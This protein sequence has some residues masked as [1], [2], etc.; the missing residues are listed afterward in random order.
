MK[1]SLLST[2][3]CVR[4]WGGRSQG[5]LQ[6][7][8]LVHLIHFR[9]PQSWCQDAGWEQKFSDLTP[10]HENGLES[11]PSRERHT[12]APQPGAISGT[13]PFQTLLSRFTFLLPL[14]QI[15][16][17]AQDALWPLSS[18]PLHADKHWAPPFSNNPICLE[19]SVL[20]L[21]L[22]SIFKL[23]LKKK[24]FEQTQFSTRNTEFL[25]PGDFKLLNNIW[26]SGKRWD[27]L[28]LL[29]KVLTSV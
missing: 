7:L 2:R 16:L 25:V 21:P 5:P 28:G 22:P 12:E 14:P 6:K 18:S 15:F 19:S 4:V 13:W 23:S 26:L 11:W 29:E 1:T 10:I 3:S 24:T 9:S 17:Y 27:P 20:S 8:A